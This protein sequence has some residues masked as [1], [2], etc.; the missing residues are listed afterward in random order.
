M[1]TGVN[2]DWEERD[3]GNHDRTCVWLQRSQS[4]ERTYA[5]RC[6]KSRC[7]LRPVRSMREWNHRGEMV[8]S[9]GPRS[10]YGRPVLP[11]L[12]GGI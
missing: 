11:T 8:R 12:P 2:P 9:R 5:I 3:L 1:N 7:W 6:K 4:P 10:I